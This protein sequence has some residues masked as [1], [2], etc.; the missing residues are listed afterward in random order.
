MSDTLGRPDGFTPIAFVDRDGVSFGIDAQYPIAVD[1][2]SVYVKDIDT[3]LSSIGDFSGAVTD[4]FDDRASSVTTETDNPSLTIALKRPIFNHD[5][6]IVAPSGGGN[7][8]NVTIVAKDTSGATLE[9]I[10]DSANDT[11]YTAKK[12]HFQ[13]IDGWCSI[14]ISFTTTDT[15]TMSFIAIPKSTPV[16]AHL[17]ALKPNGED[18]HIN[19]T[20]GGNLKVSV[21][22]MSEV[23]PV[24]GYAINHVDDDGNNANPNYYGFENKDGAWYIMKEDKSA[25][26]SVYTYSAGTS[27]YATAWTGRAGQSYAI[28]GT[29]F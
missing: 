28:F 5:L 27:D 20:A 7:F 19:A 18:T 29:T 14:V 9:T 17:V 23:N 4:L 16:D 22:E 12:Y 21:E 10:D 11:K 2:D 13:D 24:E 1:G 25:N 8:S 26:P 3:T 6:T 15:V